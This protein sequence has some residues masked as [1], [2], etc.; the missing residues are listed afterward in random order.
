MLSVARPLW[1][2]QTDELN[3]HKMPE[4]LLRVALLGHE[5]NLTPLITRELETI[6]V[7]V[8]LR[9]VQL[10]TAL[11]DTLAEFPADLVLVAP[12]K[13]RDATWPAYSVARAIRPSAPFILLTETVDEELVVSFA[14][15]NPD[16]LVHVGNL[17]RLGSAVRVA[18]ETRRPLA[19]LSPRQVQVLVNVA[20]GRSTREIA[21]SH[22]L[23]VKTV[24]SHRSAMMKRL[25]LGNVAALVRYTI[26]M[27]LVPARPSEPPAM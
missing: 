26:R 7:Q 24:E 20:E 8:V 12:S 11:E 4:P 10:D 15:Y 17:A 13:A 19:K 23:S 16:A 1:K 18:L 27:G 25:G 9:H 3:Y 5:E 14:R 2:V 21:E 6:G 22:G